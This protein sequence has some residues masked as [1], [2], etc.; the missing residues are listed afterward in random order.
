MANAGNV[1]HRGGVTQ[2][3]ALVFYESLLIG[4][5]AINRLQELGYRTTLVTDLGRLAGQARAEKPLILVAELAAESERVCEA[6]TRLRHD[7]ETNHIPVLAFAR[8]GTGR[9]QKRFEERVRGAGVSLLAGESGLLA[10]LP[11]LLDQVLAVE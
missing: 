8:R 1:S 11:G 7:P 10:Q 9:K 4:N 2:P 3:L 6:I 5:Q